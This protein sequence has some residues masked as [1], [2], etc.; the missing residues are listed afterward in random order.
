MI[1]R[2]IDFEVHPVARAALERHHVDVELVEMRQ[3]VAIRLIGREQ[4][5]LRR[6][7]PAGVAPDLGQVA[8]PFHR[9]IEH[10]DEELDASCPPP[11]RWM[12][13][14]WMFGS[15]ICTIAQPAP[16]QFQQLV[17]HRGAD[18]SNQRL[19]LRVVVVA[20]RGPDQLGRDGA[21]F[22]RPAVIPCAIFHSAAY[23]SGPRSILSTQRGITRLSITSK[24]MSPLAV[25]P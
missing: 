16:R 8:Q 12:L 20:D 9:V 4:P 10:V 15:S 2:P 21:E 7:A 1:E 3:R 17:A 24:M 11:P 14:K 6:V 18:V 13:T 19:L 5:L 22:H 25:P 23:C